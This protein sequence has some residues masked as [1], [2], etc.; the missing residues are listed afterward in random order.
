MQTAVTIAPNVTIQTELFDPKQVSSSVLCLLVGQNRF[1]LLVKNE[2]G[3]AVWLED[4]TFPSLLDSRPIPDMLADVFRNHALLTAGPW[5]EIRVGVNS[6]VFT[7]IP[8]PLYRKEYAGSYLA[9][10]RGGALPAHE[11]AHAYA[12]EAEGFLSVFDLNYPLADYFSEMYPLQPITF[13]HQT[14]ALIEATM[15]LDGRSLALGTVYL[16]FENEFV[17]ILY[18][19]AHQLQ[20]C[21]RF[22]Y[23]NA[24][25]LVYYI[26]YVLDE[27]QLTPKTVSLV[28]FGEIT[29]FAEAYTELSRFLPNI[30]FGQT[31][32]GLTLV[33]EF[34]EL[35]EHRYLSLYGLGL[36]SEG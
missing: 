26:L 9:L 14:S 27:Q 20:Y 15:R 30:T 19:Q 35:P 32:P 29:L 17:T 36:L 25:D 6:S 28:L 31:P 33:P 7:L 12:H 11:F 34:S 1:Q 13:V 2:K 10:M 24:H 22:G 5:Q 23:R 18:R 21:N 4:Y 3:Q 8:E 16:Y